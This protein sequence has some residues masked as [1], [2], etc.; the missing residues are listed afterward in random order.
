MAGSRQPF[1]SN[2]S[3]WNERQKQPVSFSLYD[4]AHTDQGAVGVVGRRGKSK[5]VCYR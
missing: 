2:S 1:S 3:N 5:A 4:I